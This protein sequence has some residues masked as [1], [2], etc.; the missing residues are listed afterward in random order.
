MIAAGTRRVAARGAHHAIVLLAALLTACGMLP[1]REPPPPPSAPETLPPPPAAPTPPPAAAPSQDG[2]PSAAEIPPDLAS[3][4]DAVP[5]VEPKSATGNPQSYSVDGGKYQVLA[6]AQGY[7]ERGLASWYGKKFHG[8]R[9]SSGEPYDMFKMTA[10]HKTLPIPSYV[11]VTNLDTKRSIIVRVN[12]RGPFHE[13]RII[14]LS[15]TAALKLGILGNGSSQV[16]VEALDP[17]KPDDAQAVLAAATK[18]PTPQA[19]QSAMTK[20][21][22]AAVA[23]PTDAAA[24]DPHALVAAAPAAAIVPFVDGD[25]ASGLVVSPAQQYTYLQ[26]G[27]F[28][29]PI[30]AVTMREQLR[31]LGIANIVLKDDARGSATVHRVLIGPFSELTALYEMRKHLIDQHVATTPVAE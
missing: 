19:V 10:A 25:N 22:P 30:N 6:N 11:R 24:I 1:Q 20:L 26:A 4:P 27:L 16:E 8:K 29:D 14:D 7:K 9:T 31:E 23:P 18:P 2:P 17:T 21:L 5:K 28:S 15:Y 3:V 12:D 13:G